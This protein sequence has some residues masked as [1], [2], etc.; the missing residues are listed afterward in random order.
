MSLS[1]RLTAAMVI[2]VAFTA[3][4]VGVLSYRN[5]EDAVLPTE[6]TRLESRAQLQGE[7]L[8]AP[9][10]A[11]RSDVLAGMGPASLEEFVASHLAGGK[12]PSD[13][14]PESVWRARVVKNFLAHLATKPDYAQLR[15]IGVANNGRE[16]I[17]VD[18][19]GPGGTVQEVPESALQQRGDR[20]YFVE[21]I[22]LKAGEVYVSPIDLNQE[23][24]GGETPYL[25]FARV[26][27]PVF[28]AGGKLFGILVVNIDMRQTLATIARSARSRGQAYV[29]NDQ[30]DY[31]LH[32]DHAR[33]FGFDLGHRYR[34]EEDFPALSPSLA[35][36]EA[37]SGTIA[38]SEKRDFVASVVPIALAGGPRVAVV[39]MVPMEEALASAAGVRGATILGGLAA[40]LAATALAV[41]FARSLTRPLMQ[42]ADSLSRF[43]GEEEINL[44]E[45]ESGEIA[46]LSRAYS[47]MAASVREKT[48]ALHREIAERA[49]LEER[50]RLYIA[51]VESASD[52]IVT[53]TIDGIITTW[54][55]GAE[56]L[57][58]YAAN[59]AIGQSI[60]LIAT[61]ELRGEQL[62][63]AERVRRGEHV[64]E[65]ETM[66]RAKNGVLREVSL[67]F[68]PIADA[69]GKPVGAS[70][71]YRDVAPRKLAE[72][73]FRM[74]VESSPSAMIM[75][76]TKGIVQLVNGETERMF[77]YAQGEL[78]GKPIEILIPANLRVSHV[79]DRAGYAAN[80][81]QR[82]MG[83]GRDLRGVRKDGSEVAV[84]IG[85]NPILTREG[86]MV[87]ASVVDVTERKL[88][89]QLLNDR[90]EELQRS[91]AELEQF[92]YVASHDLQEPLRMVASYAE[93]LAERYQGKLDA[94]ADKYI[95]YAVDG[96]KRMQRLVNDLLSFSR[97]GRA[98]TTAQ[99]TDFNRLM[100]DVLKSLD[101]AITSKGAKVEA[102]I[103]P[104]VVSDAQQMS[105]VFQN[106]ISNAIKF[107]GQTP[108][109]VT[110]GVEPFG[111]GWKFSVSD[112]GIGIEEQ[113]SERIF[114][115][116]QRLHDRTSYEGN[117][118]GLPIAKKIVER[119]GGRIWF[120]SVPGR[121]TT[122]FF[123]LP[124]NQEKAA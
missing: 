48:A 46:T 118:I 114:Q 110:I 83:A 69:S 30:G 11:A 124:Q 94:K 65:F 71:I 107:H 17:R 104:V 70:A 21:T 49:K 14:S 78:I 34:I 44:P 57:F 68:S 13:G 67:T 105:Q 90:A 19:S 53:T 66:R 20:D 121:G 95:G 93:L 92:A 86:T 97:A 50:E 102:A 62:D 32:P 120:E 81:S 79:K 82:N 9:V 6:L 23:N 85:L 51:A 36:G 29:V 61:P 115:M 35:S 4:A 108:P 8:N 27:T 122:F 22:R 76:D 37:F 100:A 41:L 47:R 84:E 77:G 43:T 52:G 119:H 45:N 16:L 39:A 73:R 38:D 1:T 24:G 87:M 33:E 60:A 91:N 75:A 3:V 64:E 5:I 80:P 106:L 88:R 40:I 98:E 112:N 74:A 10:A 15:L 2:L 111:S 26:A 101:H 99:P 89:E 12:D 28:T 42:M 55:T 109:V 96:A 7:I 116:Y 59:E 54:N 31:L 25:P 113:Y 103:L 58:G 18:R 63:H 72:Q 117:G 56:R 123:T